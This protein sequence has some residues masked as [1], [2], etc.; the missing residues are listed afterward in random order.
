MRIA[1]VE[2][3]PAVQAQLKKG[4]YRY[5]E[6]HADQAILSVFSDGEEIQFCVLQR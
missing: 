6:D 2:D 4:V 5:F 1:I 3:D